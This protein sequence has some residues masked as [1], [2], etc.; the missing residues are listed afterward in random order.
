M[1]VE[2][3]KA[4]SDDL[5]LQVTVHNR[6]PEAASVHVLP[7]LWFRNTWA[8]GQDSYRPCLAAA[9]GDA[10]AVTHEQL[11]ELHLYCD[12]AP[13]LLFCDN[14]TNAPRLYHTP[15]VLGQYYKDGINDYLLHGAPTVNPAQT[16][17]KAAAHYALTV[18]AGGS[19]SVRVRLAPAGIG[20]P[21]ADFEDLLSQRR[22]EADDYYALVQARLPDPDARAVQRQAFAGMLW[23]KQFYYYDVPQWLAGDPAF[24]LPHPRVGRA[25]TRAGST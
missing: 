1:F 14:E 16:G 19:R 22:R 3:A 25:A 5:L 23:S 15:P 2:Y 12:Q 6:G 7:Q 21:F 10:I 11:G 17:T 8:G 13:A 24:P 20:A 4:S 9:P 18:P